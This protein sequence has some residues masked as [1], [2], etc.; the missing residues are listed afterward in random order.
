MNVLVTGACGYIGSHVVRELGRAGHHVIAVDDLSYG[1]RWAVPAH[2]PFSQVGVGDSKAIQNLCS[3]HGIEA[4][5]HFAAFIDSGESVSD[6]A[7][8]YT[9]NVA[10]SLAF[11]QTLQRCR[12]RRIIFSSTAAVYGDPLQIP[13]EEDHPLRPLSPYGRT[14][15][16]CEMILEDFRSAYEMSYTTLRYFNVA[17][18][19]EDGSLGEAHEPETHLIPRILMAARKASPKLQV[20][21]DDYETSDGT[22]VRDYVH[23]EDLA[24]AHVLAL[25]KQRPGEGK[26][27]NVGGEKGFSVREVIA[28]CAAVTGREFDVSVLKRRF[29]DPP[30]L[31]ACRKKIYKE[32]GWESRFP[33]L[34]TIV[35]H[36]WRWHSRP[37]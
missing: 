17:G 10:G 33:G 16:M 14:K 3:E 37:G 24:R 23:V 29:G 31:V 36:A 25:E 9:N 19:A 2:V 35:A 8:Y 32:L 11:F 12:I 30:V 27:Y 6:P 5:M 18:A 28:V 22:C 21:G 4:A 1:N 13:I 15:M 26:V 34:E 7:K 20:F